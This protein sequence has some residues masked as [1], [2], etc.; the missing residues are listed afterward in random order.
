[1]GSTTQVEGVSAPVRDGIVWFVLEL[2]DDPDATAR[3]SDT[4]RSGVSRWAA[5]LSQAVARAV[6]SARVNEKARENQIFLR[7]FI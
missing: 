1:M 2:R 3:G 6:P 7:A 5:L 4:G